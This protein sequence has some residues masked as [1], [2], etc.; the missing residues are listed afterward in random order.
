M[1]EIVKLL[2]KAATE[3]G[4][5]GKNQRND[6]F[7]YNFRGIDALMNACGPVFHN[8][9]IVVTTEMRVVE[10][11]PQSKGYRT[12]IEAAYTFH[13]PD[14]S[15]VT[16]QVI[17]EGV[18]QS[19]KSATKAMA[20]AMKYALS[21]SLVIP[22]EDPDPDSQSPEVEQPTVPVHVHNLQQRAQAKFGEDTR[23]TLR[24]TMESLGLSHPLSPDDCVSIAEELGL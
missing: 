21:Q 1:S 5:V 6:H 15:F 12:L 4:A 13:A 20:Q 19:D 23:E 18:D 7:K 11:T 9:G 3:V 8:L 17:G 14:G 24:R 10:S 16:S 22:T 2:A